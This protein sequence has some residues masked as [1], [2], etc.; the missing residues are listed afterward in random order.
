MTQCFK[1]ELDLFSVPPIQSVVESGIWDTATLNSSEKSEGVI[2]F[3]YES[4]D[5]VDLSE[6]LMVLV[7]SI[8]QK[9]KEGNTSPY[10]KDDSEAVGPVNNFMHSLFSQ[11]TVS[12]NNK[13]VEN[14]NGYYPY[15]SYIENTLNYNVD[16][17]N[18]H[19]RSC[20]YIKDDS[21]KMNVF[22][23]TATRTVTK[24]ENN[25]EVK[26][27][28]PQEINSGWVNRRQVFITSKDV[29]LCGALN[30]SVFNTNKY[31]LPNIP[32]TVTLTR[33]KNDFC[34]M[35]NK[36][37]IDYMVSIDKCKLFFRKVKIAPSIIDLHLKALHEGNSAKYPIRRISNLALTIKSGSIKSDE[38][39]LTSGKIPRRV[40]VGLV[41]HAGFSGRFSENPFFF[42]NFGLTNLTLYVNGVP[43][44][45]AN[46]MDFDFENDNYMIGYHGLHKS[47]HRGV[48]EN[49]CAISYF[50][51]KNANTFFVF[52]LT[53]DLCDF[54]HFNYPQN[55]ILKLGYT[56]ANELTKTVS[57]ICYF[58]YDDIIEINKTRE[59][60]IDYKP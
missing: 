25:V 24:K 36:N 34:L 26:T 7:C 13:I 52:N 45:N 1:S 22:N 58:E 51:Y 29:Q 43:H 56:F 16:A 47:L 9:N 11:I 46:G 2:E 53:P 5:Y 49:G 31:L 48:W 41:D 10:L 18:S 40:I 15:R 12:L 39:Q 32:I 30:L 54:D 42:Q 38:L 14:T 4:V 19:L 21:N 6:T 8:R 59:V 17:K 28:E 60:Y 27:E 33:S 55:G 50:E 44:P 3:K 35:G 57:L 23:T 20:L 37:N